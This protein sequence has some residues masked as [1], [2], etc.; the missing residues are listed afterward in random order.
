M[1]SLIPRKV[2]ARVWWHRAELTGRHPASCNGRYIAFTPAPL[3]RGFYMNFV[4]YE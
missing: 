1:L 4:R 3:R 2:N